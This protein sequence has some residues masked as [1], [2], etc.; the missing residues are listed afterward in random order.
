MS[1]T[2]R[3]PSEYYMSNTDSDLRESITTRQNNQ[4][5]AEKLIYEKKLYQ[6]PFADRLQLLS[7]E[8]VR[9][10]DNLKGFNP[11]ALRDTTVTMGRLEIEDSIERL[12][13][14]LGLKVDFDGNVE[15]L[16]T[17]ARGRFGLSGLVDLV[18]EDIYRLEG[19]LSKVKAL[20]RLSSV[21]YF[22]GTLIQ[23]FVDMNK[24]RMRLLAL[25]YLAEALDMLNDVDGRKGGLDRISINFS[26]LVFNMIPDAIDRPRLKTDDAD[27]QTLEE[28]VYLVGNMPT[29]PRDYESLVIQDISSEREGMKRWN[30]LLVK[31]SESTQESYLDFRDR[32][33]KRFVQAARRISGQSRLPFDYYYRF[34]H[35]SD[36]KSVSNKRDLLL[37]LIT[38]GQGYDFLHAYI[39]NHEFSESPYFDDPDVTKLFSQLTAVL[40]GLYKQMIR[41]LST[42]PV[43]IPEYVTDGDVED[44]EFLDALV[45]IQVDER[46]SHMSLLHI[47]EDLGD[48]FRV[49]VISKAITGDKARQVA[50]SLASRGIDHP[51]LYLGDVF[52]ELYEPVIGI[53]TGNR[54]MSSILGMVNPNLPVS[55]VISSIKKYAEEEMGVGFAYQLDQD[56]GDNH[57]VSELTPERKWRVYMDKVAS[58]S[59][60]EHLHE[61]FRIILDNFVLEKYPELNDKSEV[62]DKLGQSHYSHDLYLGMVSDKIFI[63]LERLFM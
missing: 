52:S 37:D 6:K 22:Y 46:V 4:V 15:V 55:E 59:L 30:D 16:K 14:L 54:H 32:I 13:S 25:S 34:S 29:M 19:K 57:G 42:T 10:F 12:Q 47:P 8:A 11:L 49:N 5:R 24:Q 60:A 40:N 7:K 45:D 21:I 18:Y 35:R 9:G 61:L 39:F 33:D 17:E 26:H 3:R 58:K 23:P 53:L 51:Y 38:S 44:P 20:I 1:Y 41:G 56:Y 43:E 31:Y 50:G 27:A 28:L 48:V 63:Y 62:R 36:E 2:Y